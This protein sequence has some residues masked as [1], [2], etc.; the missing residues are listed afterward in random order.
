MRWTARRP[1]QHASVWLEKRPDR[2]I[3]RRI[4][5]VVLWLQLAIEDRWSVTI[6]DEVAPNGCCDGGLWKPKCKGPLN[7]YCAR[8]YE[9]WDGRESMMAEIR[10][11]PPG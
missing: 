6:I 2:R 1:P 9:L 10:N 8:A 7:G 5:L 4:G 3:G 11:L